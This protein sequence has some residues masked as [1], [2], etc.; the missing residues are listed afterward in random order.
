[1][2]HNGTKAGAATTTRRDRMIK[3]RIHD[4]YHVR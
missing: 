2:R 1:M 3:E 4:P